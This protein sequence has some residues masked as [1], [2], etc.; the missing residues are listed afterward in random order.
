MLASIAFLIGV[1]AAVIIVSALRR[2]GPGRLGPDGAPILFGRLSLIW[3]LLGV[4][5]LAIGVVLSSRGDVSSVF[6]LFSIPCAT[7]GIILAITGLFA[8]D[9]HWPTLVGL[10]S[11]GALIALWLA[12]ALGNI[13][14]PAA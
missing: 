3:G 12:F 5:G 7:I 6:L 9:R 11:N 13:L 2:S 10:V 14:I 8:Q 4:L 1:I